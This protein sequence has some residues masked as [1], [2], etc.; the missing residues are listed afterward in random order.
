MTKDTSK[1]AIW[2]ALGKT[3]PAHTKQFQRAGGFR[4]TAIKPMWAN[5]RMTE[6][7][8]PC[9]I[10]WGMDKPEFTLVEAAGEILVYCTL[11]MW[12]RKDAEDGV[13]SRGQVYGVG[14]DKVVSQVFLKDAKGQKIVD[15][16]KGGY[17][18]YPQTDDEAYKKAFTDAIGNAMKFV[19][20]GADVHMGLFDDSKY[21]QEVRGEFED[22]AKAA[23]VA[24]VERQKGQAAYWDKDAQRIEEPRPDGPKNAPQAPQAILPPEL[25]WQYNQSSGVLLCRILEAQKRTAKDGKEYVVLAINNKLDETN[26]GKPMLFYWHATHRDLLLGAKKG[27]SIK[28]VITQKIDK[29]GPIFTIKELREFDGKVLD[30]P[31]EVPPVAGIKPIGDPETQARLLGSNLSTEEN[32]FTE[33]DLMGLHTLCNRNWQAVLEFLQREQARREVTV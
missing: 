1:L 31:K 12:W 16:E 29:K 32:P 3:D 19:G 24:E 6:Y 5:K 4:G 22:A 8:G 23:V 20:V 28:A 13:V 9:G 33:N 27:T 25:D 17:K 30:T 10:G 2:E 14:G 11:S 15:A 7:F 26:P 18:T 21:V